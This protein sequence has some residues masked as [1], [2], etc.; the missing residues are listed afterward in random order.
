MKKKK[1]LFVIGNL[2]A[3]G[4][5]KSLVSLLNSMPLDKYEVYYQTTLD[6]A[7]FLS[8]MPK[9]CK[10]KPYPPMLSAIGKGSIRKLLRNFDILGLIAKIHMVI[11]TRLLFKK[12][13]LQIIQFFWN[14]GKKWVPQDPVHYDVA[15]GYLEGLCNY[16]VIDKT[17]ADTK[18]LWMHNYYHKLNCNP[19]FD[20]LY[21]DQADYICT[22]S[23]I[24]KDDLISAIPSLK[25]KIHV[26]ENISSI[27]LIDKQKKQKDS[28]SYFQDK[29]FKIIS[30]GRLA[31]QKGYDLAIN[32]AKILKSKGINFCWYVI[33]DGNLRKDLEEQV[34][35][36]GIQDCFIL[37]GLR[38]NPYPYIQDA[39]VYCMPSR[40]EGKS[41]ALDEAIILCKPIVVTNFPSVYDSI[42]NN[43]NGVI[44][45]MT[46]FAIAEG[47]LQ[48]YHNPSIRNALTAYLSSHRNSN[49]QK[50][51]SNFLP[52]IE[53]YKSQPL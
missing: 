18:I 26:I 21:F 30:V 9:A 1:I 27:R 19:D 29:R 17:I 11:A 38:T 44:V 14:V 34:L 49:E 50:V 8:H 47:I 41:I 3:G 20:K 42:K 32:A 35:K 2:H 10:L 23:Q 33:G 15:I 53:T 16:Y 36:N 37:M 51:L 40:F 28:D 25:D 22:M 43:Q 31:K 46:A 39:N 4:A 45:D 7:F 5:Q 12:S 52:L 24:C 6:N 48:L 13:G